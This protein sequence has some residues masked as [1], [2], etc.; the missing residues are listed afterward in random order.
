MNFLNLHHIEMCEMTVFPSQ[1]STFE[2]KFSFVY[3]EME[4]RQVT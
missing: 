2:L 4:G 3:F 1:I